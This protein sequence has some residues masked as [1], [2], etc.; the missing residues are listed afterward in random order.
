[1]LI[2]RNGFNLYLVIALM[3]GLAAGCRSPEGKAKSKEKKLL[4]TFR[5]HLETKTDPMGRTETAEV[6]R[7]NPVKFTIDKAPFL[8][9]GSVKEATVTEVPGGFALQIQFDR[10]RSWLLEQYTSAN[11]TKHLLIFSQFFAPGEDKLNKGRWLS[12]PQ[13][14]NHITDGL[15]IFTPDA[16]KEEAQ[17][18]AIGLNHVA[19]KLST[20]KEVKW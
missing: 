10:Q 17:R 20:G 8:T 2:R 11:R 9:E 1:M 15:L 18:F 16:T 12:A 6:Y 19:E 3:V 4:S 13:I 5:L 14:R 7:D